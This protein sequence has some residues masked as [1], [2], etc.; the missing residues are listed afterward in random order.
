MGSELKAGSRSFSDT[1]LFCFI[2]YFNPLFVLGHCFGFPLYYFGA[3]SRCMIYIVVLSIIVISSTV[4]GFCIVSDVLVL[5]ISVTTTSVPL[6]NVD[7]LGI[8]FGHSN[9]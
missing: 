9:L 7:S 1:V 4:I 6:N 3:L 5:L 8:T 2:V